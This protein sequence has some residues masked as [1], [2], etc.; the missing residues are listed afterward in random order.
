MTGEMITLLCTLLLD[1]LMTFFF[2][3]NIVRVLWLSFFFGVLI[4]KKCRKKHFKTCVNFAAYQCLKIYKSKKQLLL[5][6]LSRLFL[7]SHSKHNGQCHH[8]NF[9]ISMFCIAMKRNAKHKL[10]QDLFHQSKEFQPFKSKFII[11]QF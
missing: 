6:K 4:L 9:S 1:K 2:K 8:L 5:L 11:F 10:T 3:K 7:S